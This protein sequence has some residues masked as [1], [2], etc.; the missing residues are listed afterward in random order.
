MVWVTQSNAVVML[1]NADD[2]VGVKSIKTEILF[3]FPPVA[4]FYHA[5]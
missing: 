1:T 2:V 3:F 4:H 5:F